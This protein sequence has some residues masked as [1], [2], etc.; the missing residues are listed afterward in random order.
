MFEKKNSTKVEMNDE[1]K[2]EKTE[3]MKQIDTFAKG[4]AK[5]AIDHKMEKAGI[6]IIASD[7]DVEKERQSMVALMGSGSAVIDGIESAVVDNDEVA[8]LLKAGMT[9]GMLHRVINGKK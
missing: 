4:L 7:Q 9:I 6:I 8:K 2:E 1:V 5:Y 3:F